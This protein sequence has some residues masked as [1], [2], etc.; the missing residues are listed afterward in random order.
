MR[1]PAVFDLPLPAGLPDP[2]LWL[3]YCPGPTLHDVLSRADIGWDEKAALLGRFGA[4]VARRF[5]EAARRREP[6]LLHEHGTTKHVLL[7]GG[8]SGRWADAALC[9]I[10]LEGGFRD[11]FPIVEAQGQELGGHLRSIAK[12]VPDR[13]DDAFRALVRDPAADGSLR[14]AA[15]HGAR[16]RG[17]LRRIRRAA[18]RSRRPTFAKTALLERLAALSARLR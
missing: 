17:L 12:A 15:L 6:L 16:S 3:E 9:W 11:G 18:D 2:A 5:A 14:A 4:D 7:P 13:V 8:G 1:V 10:D